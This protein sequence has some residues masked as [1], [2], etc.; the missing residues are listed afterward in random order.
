LRG[1]SSI[2]AALAVNDFTVLVLLSRNE[3]K[4][5]PPIGGGLHI[6][7]TG[8]DIFRV[9][10]EDC[11]LSSN[12]AWLLLS[13]HQGVQPDSKWDA[14]YILLGMYV[15]WMLIFTGALA[16]LVLLRPGRYR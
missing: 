15:F 9:L 6:F 7:R 2:A 4:L 11:R 13:Y 1:Q 12:Q 5:D 10:Q 14:V 3:K 16:G 8:C